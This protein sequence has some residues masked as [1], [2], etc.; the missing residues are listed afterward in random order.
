MKHKAAANLHKIL[1][2]E[3]NALMRGQIN[4][5]LALSAQKLDLSQ[6]LSGASPAELARLRQLA[7][8]NQGLFDSA[9]QGIRALLDR[10]KDL[11]SAQ[12]GL[13]TY[14]ENGQRET[15]YHGKSGKLERRA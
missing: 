5:A 9:A 6:K 11:Q 13:Q 3:A 14:T 1:E 10:M 7:T 15:I 2:R 4:D 12:N 8:R